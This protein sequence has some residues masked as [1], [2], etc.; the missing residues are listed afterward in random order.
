[1][2]SYP[3]F[4]LKDFIGAKSDLNKAIKIKPNEGSFYKLRGNAKYMLNDGK[5]ACI[6]WSKAATLGDKDGISNIKKWC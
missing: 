6:D 3:K 1:M 2:R 4:V 5:N